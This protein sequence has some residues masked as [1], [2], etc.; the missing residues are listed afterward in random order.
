MVKWM[1]DYDAIGIAE[2]FIAHDRP[3]QYY[4]AWQHLI[5]EGLC[6]SPKKI[7]APTE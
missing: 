2:G 5:E 6:Q 3:S 7:K 1:S 4:E